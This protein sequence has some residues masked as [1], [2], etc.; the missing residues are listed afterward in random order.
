M[1]TFG[2]KGPQNLFLKEK[3]MSD[4][5]LHNIL[6]LP[7]VPSSESS[8]II[9]S[10]VDKTPPHIWISVFGYVFTI[11]IKGY[12]SH[13]NLSSLIDA[14]KR[15]QT[16]CIFLE[17][18]KPLYTPEY[19]FQTLN[20][21]VVQY[22]KIVHGKTTCLNPLK[23]YLHKAYN[24]D[25]EQAS[26]IFD[27]LKTLK[28]QQVYKNVFHLNLQR[29]LSVDQGFIIKTYTLNEINERILSLSDV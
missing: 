5:H 22:G 26:V 27:L 8:Y 12:T 17:L 10:G 19:L 16:K 3:Y 9:L 4:Y 6:P 13:K 21:I 29:Y 24:L 11:D 23:D 25:T 18:S 28:S 14:F 1:K 7:E 15:N 20:H 2:W